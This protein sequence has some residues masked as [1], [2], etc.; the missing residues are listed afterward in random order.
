MATEAPADKQLSLDLSPTPLASSPVA[1]VM[2]FVD[3]TTRAVRQAAMERVKSSGI[4]E[5]PSRDRSG[6]V[7]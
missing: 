6:S 5:T 7:G 1:K 4:F 3:A 2:S